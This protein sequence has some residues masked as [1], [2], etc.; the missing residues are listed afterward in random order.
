MEGLDL[1][2]PLSQAMEEPSPSPSPS[3]P[4]QSSPSWNLVY[5]SDDESSIV[6]SDHD[7][8]MDYIIDGET[9]EPSTANRRSNLTLRFGKAKESGQLTVTMD[10]QLDSTTSVKGGSLKDNVVTPE[11]SF[12]VEKQQG[13]KMTLKKGSGGVRSVNKQQS[14]STGASSNTGSQ[15]LY[16][17]TCN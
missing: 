5:P 10:S 9:E 8:D 7:S 14:I 12:Q 6:E 17:W 11:M 2:N 16:F 4:P 13:L 3:P 1:F 15:V